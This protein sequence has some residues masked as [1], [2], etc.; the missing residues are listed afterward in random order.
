MIVWPVM[1]SR[2]MIPNRRPALIQLG[3]CQ[4]TVSGVMTMKNARTTS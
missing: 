4:T 3:H 2:T 1:S